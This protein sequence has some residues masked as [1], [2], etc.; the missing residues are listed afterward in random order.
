MDRLIL[1]A[2]ALFL[3][4]GLGPAIV[5]SK[6]AAPAVET[7]QSPPQLPPYGPTT[8]SGCSMDPWGCP[9]GGN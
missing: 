8:E 7:Q 1:L 2:I 5:R 6:A 4:T 9:D 3:A